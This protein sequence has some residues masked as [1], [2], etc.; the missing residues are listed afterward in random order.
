ML[1]PGNWLHRVNQGIVGN[2][3]LADV[4]ESGRMWE[5]LS[6]EGDLPEGRGVI[7]EEGTEITVK[8]RSVR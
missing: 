7:I 4:N 8:L 1:V 2:V 5:V 3:K 6:I